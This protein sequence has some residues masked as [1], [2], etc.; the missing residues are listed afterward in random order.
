MTGCFDSSYKL[1]VSCC[2]PRTPAAA[3]PLL[4][5]TSSPRNTFT[6]RLSPHSPPWHHPERYAP[7]EPPRVPARPWTAPTRPRQGRPA[8]R[9]AGL[10]CVG[11][12]HRSCPP[13]RLPELHTQDTHTRVC[14]RTQYSCIRSPSLLPDARARASAY[15]PV[16][17]VAL[18]PPFWPTRWTSSR[19]PTS[20]RSAVPVRRHVRD[21]RVGQGGHGAAG[22]RRG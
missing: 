14:P 17:L 10:A 3:P 2:A 6:P 18:P 12:A 1:H 7:R 20:P 19:V 15:A 5:P 22:R 4:A 8:D 11:A 13:G 16:L 21:A 9:R